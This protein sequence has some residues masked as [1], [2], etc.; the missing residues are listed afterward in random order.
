[1]ILILFMLLVGLFNNSTY[2]PERY[3]ICS[4]Y[5]YL[6][7]SNAFLHIKLLW[8]L[9]WANILFLIMHTVIYVFLFSFLKTIFMVNNDLKPVLQALSHL[10]NLFRVY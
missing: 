1:M 4:L 3:L 5:E 8:V 6:I 10:R 9:V 7:I 2:K